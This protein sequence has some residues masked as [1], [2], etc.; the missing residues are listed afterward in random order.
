MVGLA[1]PVLL[2]FPA[3]SGPGSSRLLVSQPLLTATTTDAVKILAS[4]FASSSPTS[5]TMDRP[6]LV[7]LFSSL[8]SVIYETFGSLVQHDLS[9]LSRLCAKFWPKWLLCVTHSNRTFPLP[10]PPSISPTVPRSSDPTHRYRAPERPAQI[11]LHPRAPTPLDAPHVGPYHLRPPSDGPPRLRRNHARP[12]LPAPASRRSPLPQPFPPPSSSHR[13]RPFGRR[14]AAQGCCDRGGGPV[15]C[16]EFAGTGKVVAVGELL[17]RVQSG[18]IGCE[19]LCQ[20]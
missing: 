3:L 4:R 1:A 17:C 9:E 20:G 5:S 11:R 12:P 15:P 7:A 6:T 18:Q 8:A 2:A 19:D 13:V 16:E 10:L 14:C